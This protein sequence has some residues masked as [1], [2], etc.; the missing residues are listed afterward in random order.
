MVAIPPPPPTVAPN[1]A[2]FMLAEGQHITRIFNPTAHGAT[3]LSFRHFGPISR[4]DHHRAPYP[5]R[6]NDIERGIIYGAFTLS[7]CIVEIFGDIKI[8]DVGTFEVASITTTRTLQ[9][10]DLRG[11][12]AM[13]AGTVTAVSKE[14]DRRISQQWSRYIYDQTFIFEEIDGL[15]YYNAHNDEEAF[16]LYERASNGLH[17]GTGDIKTLRDPSL[18]TAIQNIAAE[19]NMVIDPY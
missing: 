11:T 9:L 10:L 12:G 6:A 4:F 3:A 2:F 8:I 18:R 5:T 7:C 14:S 16:A 17:C 1:P 15:V 19:N 13:R